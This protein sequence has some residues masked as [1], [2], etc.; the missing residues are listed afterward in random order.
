VKL[1]GADLARACLAL[2]TVAP[3]KGRGGQELLAT[4]GGDILLIDESYNANP[5]S[6]A[7]ALSL[8]TTVSKS[9]KGRKIAVLGDM[10]ELGQ[11]SAE[12]HIGLTKA[13]DE[14]AIDLL[15]AAGPMMRELWDAV[16]VARRGVHAE[17]SAGLTLALV[18]SLRAGD[19]VVVKGSFGSNMG[20]VVEALRQRFRAPKKEM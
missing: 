18:T 12:L 14:A 10:L 5:Q 20:L 11:F 8:L 3:A 9:R 4:N 15:Y 1:A 16:P 19:S 17:T 13:L 2:S 6:M 7:A